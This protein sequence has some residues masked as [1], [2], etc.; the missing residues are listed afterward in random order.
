M[1]SV[2][3][4]LSAMTLAVMCMELVVVAA[5]AWIHHAVKI[6]ATI[7]VPVILLAMISK[8]LL[9]VSPQAVVC[10]KQMQVCI[11]SLHRTLAAPI[12]HSYQSMH[13]TLGLLCVCVMVRQRC[14]VL[15]CIP[16]HQWS[17]AS[18]LVGLLA[19]GSIR[20]DPCSKLPG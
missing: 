14:K 17:F 4:H 3:I 15:V 1:M 5:S 20:Q 10:V 2:S 8:L 18:N 12:V 9:V 11:V 13:Q 6:I 7:P 16:T 19:N